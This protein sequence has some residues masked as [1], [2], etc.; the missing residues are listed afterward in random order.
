MRIDILPTPAALP[1]TGSAKPEGEVPQD[2]SSFLAVIGQMT[3]QGEAPTRARNDSPQK[4]VLA[5]DEDHDRGATT[6]VPIPLPYFPHTEIPQCSISADSGKNDGSAA[7]GHVAGEMAPEME[8]VSSTAPGVPDASTL[9]GLEPPDP[10][11][12]QEPDP[13]AGEENSG[14]RSEA[15]VKTAS[16]GQA[17]P[18]NA[19]S[20]SQEYPPTASETTLDLGSAN[21][22][23]PS[24]PDAPLSGPGAGSETGDFQSP[25][26]VASGM[27]GEVGVSAQVTVEATVANPT[28]VSP[29]PDPLPVSAERKI[30]GSE[31]S[32]TP[33]DPSRHTAAEEPGRTDELTTSE[34]MPAFE[35]EEWSAASLLMNRPDAPQGSAP[36]TGIF[37]RI[38]PEVNLEI[39]EVFA[40]ATDANAESGTVPPNPVGPIERMLPPEN[41]VN[42][43]DATEMGQESLSTFP[44]PSET[45]E[46]GGLRSGS[47]G[48]VAS[49]DAESRQSNLVP[50]P[51]VIESQ[52]DE[53]SEAKLPVELPESQSEL[54]LATP[55]A[56]AAVERTATGDSVRQDFPELHDQAQTPGLSEPAASAILTRDEPAPDMYS[57]EPVVPEPPARPSSMATAEAM[58]D[59]ASAGIL[60]STIHSQGI[61]KSEVDEFRSEVRTSKTSARRGN[62]KS[63]AMPPAATPS[64]AP[65][66][67]AA[68]KVENIAV[69]A[70]AEDSAKQTPETSA[71][72]R[73]EDISAKEERQGEQIPAT[74]DSA[75][76]AW[77]DM[78]SV[79]RMLFHSL[80][81]RTGSS[82]S[83]VFAGIRPFQQ[84]A[85]MSSTTWAAGFSMPPPVAG[86]ELKD[87]IAL[88]T[89]KQG[90]PSQTPEF[91]SQLTERI[92]AQLRNHEN[93]IRIQLKPGTMGRMEINAETSAAGVLATIITESANVKEYLEHNLHWLQQSFQDQGLKVDRI[94]VTVQQDFW[95]QHSASGQQESSSGSY[96]QDSRLAGHAGGGLAPKADELTLDPETL[97]ILNP[98]GT[99]HAI[100]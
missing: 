7:P 71:G 96:A 13:L 83:P 88:L 67:G 29:I 79:Q 51:A 85:S 54:A 16:A 62:A 41:A 70:N 46:G 92:Q 19:A 57:A 55:D 81:G 27:K 6:P 26:H 5:E 75:G 39:H 49:T 64:P 69:P 10:V 50:A 2:G 65:S 17:M 99:F 30:T 32:A 4:K 22:E 91:L 18:E 94:N 80:T 86:T 48:S 28:G 100:A 97:A 34:G 36:S 74:I 20:R 53:T 73:S 58:P 37:P 56:P 61:S 87:L 12:V 8:S 78:Q 95:S 9:S 68:T 38:F 35:A 77:E 25:M 89:P 21:V 63:P 43:A 72:G 14:A 3:G 47:P 76:F 42:A 59:P 66:Q 45:G 33:E 40:S 84:A 23:S 15:G 93:I 11:T 1:E 24:M 60:E 98:H 82:D 52:G 31:A 44:I 90:G